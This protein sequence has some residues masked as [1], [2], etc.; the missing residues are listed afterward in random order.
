M[1]MSL[2][3]LLYRRPSEP[4]AIQV[5]FDGAIYLVRMRRHRQARRYT[6]RIHAATR[7]VVLTMPPR[8]SVQGGQGIRPEARR[9]DRGAA[10]PA[11]GGRAFRARRGGAAARR[12]A[13]HRARPRRARHGVGR[14]ATSGERLLCVAGEA[15]HVARRVGDFLR[16]EARRDLEAASRR[17]ARALGV[18]IKRIS[19]RDQSSRWGSCSTTGVL[20]YL[21]AADPGAAVRARL[22]RRARGRA[23]RRDEPLAAV[24]AAGRAASVPSRPRQGLARRPRHRPAPLRRRAA[25]IGTAIPLARE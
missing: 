17:A 9:L 1:P 6:L 23:S 8:G 11:A 18:A 2:R 15:P 10:A 3:A 7:E 13:P 25:L 5:V 12:P 4:P 21:L 20:S 22:S 16:R 24:L 19:V 14:D